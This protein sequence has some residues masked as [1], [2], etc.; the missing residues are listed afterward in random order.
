MS[1]FPEPLNNNPQPLNSNNKRKPDNKVEKK[2]D[3]LVVVIN[4]LEHKILSLENTILKL[5]RDPET[6]QT[7]KVKKNNQTRKSRTNIS[8]D[9]MKKLKNQLSRGIYP[10]MPK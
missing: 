1:G 6:Q 4:S 10:E 8:K 9:G 5:Q 2:I 3:N 7:K